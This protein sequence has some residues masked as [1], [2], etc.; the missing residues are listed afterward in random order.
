MTSSV[1]RAVAQHPVAT[2][3][4]IGLGAAFLVGVIRPIADAQVLPFDLPLHGVVGGVF[5]VGLG[6]F[7]VTYALSGLNR[8]GS[9]GGSGY[10]TSTSGWSVRFVA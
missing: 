8:T 5:G 7:L 10:W 1:L 9:D 2:F 6:A 4:V 3:M